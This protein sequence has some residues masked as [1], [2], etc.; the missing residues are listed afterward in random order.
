MMRVTKLDG[1]HD[2]ESNFIQKMFAQKPAESMFGDIYCSFSN[3]YL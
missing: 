3:C 1:I 2:F